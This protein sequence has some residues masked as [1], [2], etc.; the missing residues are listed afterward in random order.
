MES[1][2]RRTDRA[3]AEP[4]GGRS[5]LAPTELPEQRHSTC[6]QVV[7]RRDD[8]EPPLLDGTGDHR[9]APLQEASLHP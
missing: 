5:P 2:W 1:C 4:P 3:L 9:R 6:S 8:F 7:V